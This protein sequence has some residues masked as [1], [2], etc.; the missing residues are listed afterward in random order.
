MKFSY[1]AILLLIRSVIS[2]E[3]KL[4]LIA[5][6]RLTIVI[7]LTFLYSRPQLI[8]ILIRVFLHT[9]K[10]NNNTITY[11]S[12][13]SKFKFICYFWRLTL[14]LYIFSYFKNTL[15]ISSGNR[16]FFQDQ[17]RSFVLIFYLIQTV[18]NLS[19]NSSFC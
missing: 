2:E 18:T 1:Q 13:L 7:K 3:G 8:N 17:K 15:K 11:L 9:T 10:Q 16:T 14:K 5:L 6:K 12:K 19:T 4:F